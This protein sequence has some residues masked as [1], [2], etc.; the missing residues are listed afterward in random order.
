MTDTDTIFEDEAS[1]AEFKSLMSDPASRAAFV[2]LKARAA[3]N[4]TRLKY[5][6]VLRAVSETPWAMRPAMIGV[7]VDILAYRVAGGRLTGEEIEARVAGARRQQTAG[8]T[9]VAVI[10][11]HG[12]IMP[13][14]SMMS[15]MSGGT[16]IA[17]L[18][19]DFRAALAA[20]DVSAIVF[21]IDSPGGMADGVPEMAAEIRAARGQKPIVSV[22][23]TLAA[24]AAYWLATQADQVF[25][26]KSARV[27]SIGVYT[28][29]EDES[30]KADHE[31]VKT[32]LISAG[33]F[34]TEGNP[35]EPLTD[36]AR[37]ALQSMVDDLYGMFLSDVAKGRGVGVADVRGGFGEGRVVQARAALSGG[38]IDKIAT[39]D[40]VIA[41]MHSTA[42]RAPAAAA[43]SFASGT[44]VEIP[45]TSTSSTSN[46]SD[47]VF[48]VGADGTVVGEPRPDIEAE[49][50]SVV[51]LSEWDA[52]RAML[53]C[54]TESDYRSVCAGVRSTGE[55]DKPNHWSL[56]HHYRGKPAN[57]AGV[58]H[59][60]SL[61]STAV[62]I[63]NREEAQMHL[64]AHMREINP[65]AVAAA[66]EA[67]GLYLSDI[68][69]DGEMLR[70]RTGPLKKP[71]DVDRSDW[72]AN[73]ALNQCVTEE[74]FFS[75]CAGRRETGKP[76]EREHWV[77]AHH[78]LNKP[79][80]I[81]GVR[82]ALARMP[83][84]QSIANREDAE[85]HLNFH[86]REISPSGSGL[87]PDADVL[88]EL[89]RAKSLD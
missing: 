52:E 87:T 73:K 68:D 57:A 4:G 23:N 58:R 79:A 54:Q 85:R 33:K 49:S 6:H 19:N 9:G 63:T 28:S 11:I 71:A 44:Y 3:E 74:D 53:E 25:A 30:V 10:P 36:E 78:Y 43:R 15:E 27:G 55:P 75:I 17:G 45:S 31:G 51:D 69:P 7:I 47:I 12:V 35:F 1:I 39:L 88:A 18:R 67:V 26:S 83:H 24:S 38:M 64:D 86:L 42:R 32:T 2:E 40:E 37:G 20:P 59:A 80:N 34:K 62:G 46:A 16:S 60:L 70:E 82:N 56:A 48:K 14:A 13:K 72:E 8:P 84:V 21:D 29:H 5:A 81:E 50:A 89:R 66:R 22:A 65:D 77:L 61:V 41:D 76:D